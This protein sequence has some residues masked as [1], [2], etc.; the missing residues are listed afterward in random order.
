MST[1][2]RPTGTTGPHH[3]DM[4]YSSYVTGPQGARYE[5]LKE[6]HHTAEDVKKAKAYLKANF[7]VVSI[8]VINE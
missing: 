4:L 7:D 8:K 6:K 1:D 5:L 2:F 3:H